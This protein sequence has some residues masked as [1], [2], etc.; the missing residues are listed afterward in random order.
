MTDLR[1]RL[2]AYRPDLLRHCYR[3]LGS[4]AD[5]EDRVQEVLLN[6]WRARESYAGDAPLEHWLYRIATNACLNELAKRRRRGLPQV[7]RAP[8]AAPEPLEE[9]EVADWLTPAP[10]AQIFASPA[11]LLETRESVALAFL[12]LLQRLPPRQRAVLLLK[13]V[14]GWQAEEIATALELSLASVSS[15]LHRARQS[16]ASRPATPAPDPAP[17]VLRAYVQSWESHDVESL[18]ALLHDEVVFAMP[19]HATWFLGAAAVERFLRGSRFATHWAAA[20]FRVV[21]TRANGQLALAFYRRTDRDYRP[22]SLQLV[23]F[24]DGRVTEVMSFIGPGYLRGFEVPD[25]L[26]LA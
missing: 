2:S 18:V 1:E 15:A 22:S 23:R 24:V 16:I 12:A 20:R 9:H 17:E 4:F 14:I 19:P 6:A 25:H 21:T 5:A 3:M 11:R 10:D 13:D 8:A 26:P 7:E